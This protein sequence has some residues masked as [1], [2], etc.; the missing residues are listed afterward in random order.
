[1]KIAIVSFASL[2]GFLAV[3]TWWALESSGVAVI[4]T[5]ASDGSLRST[6][7]WFVEPNGELWLEAGTP[8]NPWYLDIL[9]N[10][11]VSFSSAQQPRQYSARRVEEPGAQD[12]IRSLLRKK[13]GVRDRWIDLIFDTSRSVAVRL[14]PPGGKSPVDAATPR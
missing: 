6:H 10:P 13:Y 2:I 9:R 8:E 11:R 1:V 4:E 5:R 3:F 7:V 14:V 12:R